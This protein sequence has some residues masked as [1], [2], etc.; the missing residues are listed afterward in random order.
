MSKLMAIFVILIMIAFIMPSLLNQ[1]SRPRM[2]AQDTAMWLYNKDKKI[3]V[4]DLREATAQLSVLRGLMTDKFLLAQQDIRSILLSQLLFPE[5]QSGVLISDELKNIVMQNRLLISP[6][7]IDEFFRQSRGRAELFYI[8][9]KDEAAQAGCAV[10]QKYAGDALNIV[11]PQLTNNQI[12]AA[13][14]VKNISSSS[15]M[16]DEQIVGIFADILSVMTYSRIVT[17]IENVTQS[18]LENIYARANEEIDVNFVQ[19]SADQFVDK[20]PQ[21]SQAQLTGQFEQFKDVTAGR[22]TEENPLGF[23]Y[24]LS[25]RVALD[26]MIIKLDDL[27]QN[28]TPPTNEEIEDY[29]RQN[30]ERPPITTEVPLDP[31]DPNSEMVKRQKSFSEVADMIKRGLIARKVNLLASKILNQ[32]IEK[33]DGGFETIDFETADLET[34]KAKAGDYNSVAQNISKEYDVKIYNGRTALLN[35]EDIQSNRYLGS[36]AMVGQSRMPT[37]L[38]KLA[39]AVTQLGDEAAKLGPFEPAAPKLFVTIGPLSDR[40][41]S[42]MGIVRVV[43]AENSQAPESIDFSYEKNLHNIDETASVENDKF[44]LKDVVVQDCKK[45]L[46]AEIAEKAANEFTELVKKQSWDEALNKIN[47]SYGKKDVNEP[48]AKTFEVQTMNNLKRISQMD[49]EMTRMRVAGMAASERIIAQSV[50]YSKLIDA[51][52]DKYEQMQAKQETTP[53]ILDFEPRLSYYVIKDL[54]VGSPG[55]IEEFEQVRQQLALQQDFID[56]QSMGIEFFMPDNITAR[57]NL[58]PSADQNTPPQANDANGEK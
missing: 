12:D 39:F 1:L 8:L 47:A 58:R 4:E 22:I 10:S 42:I 21:P 40:G 49:I 13:S 6:A 51:L 30:L 35:A 24:K 54:N 5:S 17:D 2:R 29:Y 48:N 23:G 41:N 46:A 43:D 20:V 19:F 52:H 44:V 9:L 45:L 16:S 32:A 7:K 28:A 18:Q 25:P 31:N 15:G 3:S 50:I 53:A 37:Q 33:T 11:I 26:Y 57:A 38:T 34:F 36:L 55:T 56:S 14:L 27:K